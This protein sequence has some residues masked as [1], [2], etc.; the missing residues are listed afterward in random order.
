MD[1]NEAQALTYFA[2]AMG[3]V[4]FVYVKTKHWLPPV[5]VALVYLVVAAALGIVR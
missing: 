4:L 2:V 3:S 5:F 1:G